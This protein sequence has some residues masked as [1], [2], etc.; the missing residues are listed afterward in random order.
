[1]TVSVR[2]GPRS[3]SAAVL[4][5]LCVLTAQGCSRPVGDSAQGKAQTTGSAAPDYPIPARKPGYWRQV[6]L[7]DGGTGPVELKI[8]LDKALDARLSWWGTATRES[9]SR[10]TFERQ[11]DGSWRFESDCTSRGV[12]T[13]RSGAVVGDFDQKYQVEAVMTITGA[14]SAGMNGTR[15]ITIDAE[16]IGD[17]PTD[18]RPGDVETASGARFNVDETLKSAGQ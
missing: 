12:R 9:C 8:C 15:R 6:N 3:V 14:P 7:V 18:M 16:R 1:M 2:F 10:N 11:E 4:A 17:C 13:Q 5:G